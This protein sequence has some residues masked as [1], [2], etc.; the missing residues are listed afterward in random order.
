MTWFQRA[1]LSGHPTARNRLDETLA[2]APT[3]IRL[4]SLA[5]L[6]AS[7]VPS[8]PPRRGVGAGAGAGAGR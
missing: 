2:A 1:K 4:A 8:P 6:L 5:A 3:P 7:V